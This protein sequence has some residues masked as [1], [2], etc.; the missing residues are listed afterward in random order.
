MSAEHRESERRNKI[1]PV[2]H[3]AADAALEKITRED[4]FPRDTIMERLAG[5]DDSLLT[6]AL[7]HGIIIGSRC[8]PGFIGEPEGAKGRDRGAAWHRG[9]D[10]YVMAVRITGDE[11][12]IDVPK[13]DIPVVDT[14]LNDINNP[15]E[16]HNQNLK[17][18]TKDFAEGIR[19][20]HLEEQVEKS[21]HFLFNSNI[22]KS[23]DLVKKLCLDCLL[24]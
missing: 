4:L 19:M 22:V 3:N 7:F 12:G 11:V 9:L 13:L 8:F 24:I 14:Y 20:G 17:F 2:T 23:N 15:N 21:A 5:G 6:E 10:T 16:E 18:Y 1:I